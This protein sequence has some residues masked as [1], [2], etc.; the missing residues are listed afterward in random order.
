MWI[1]NWKEFFSAKKNVFIFI[2]NFLFLFASLNIFTQ[3]LVFN[4]NRN[5]T[6]QLN[7][8]I[9]EFFNAVNLDTIA[10]AFIYISLISFLIYASFRPK[11]LMM[12]VTSYTFLVWTRLF[13]MYVTPLDVPA[14]AIEFN[15]PLVFLLGTG[16]PV[17]KDLFFS[18]HTST[19]TLITLLAFNAPNFSNNDIKLKADKYFKYFLLVSLIIVAM[20]VILQKAHYTID[21]F[22]APF[23]AF[24]VYALAKKIY[25]V[26]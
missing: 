15:D 22:A 26:K 14:G 8:P 24:G 17:M 4:E 9:L 7:D 16:Q 21:V 1:K 12:A 23:F 18:G 10:F 5:Y 6:V 20:C 2:F 19:L 3:F 25:G 13:T 11:L